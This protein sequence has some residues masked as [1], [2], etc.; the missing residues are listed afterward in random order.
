VAVCN[1][2]C[3]QMYDMPYTEWYQGLAK[4]MTTFAVGGDPHSWDDKY[5]EWRKNHDESLRR[6]YSDWLEWNIIE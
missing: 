6:E 3:V 1:P 4:A 5:R 2:R